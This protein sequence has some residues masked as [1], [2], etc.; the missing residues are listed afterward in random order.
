MLN[1]DLITEF[2]GFKILKRKTWFL[3]K[4]CYFK[5]RSEN[6]KKERATQADVAHNGPPFVTEEKC[7]APRTDSDLGTNQQALCLALL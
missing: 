5:I 6:R 3:F 7:K 4:K 1:W 2:N